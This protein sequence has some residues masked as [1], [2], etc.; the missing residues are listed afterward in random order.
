LRNLRR[1]LQLRWLA[2]RSRDA[3]PVG[4]VDC[5]KFR[6]SRVCDENLAA[7]SPNPADE[8]HRKCGVPCLSAICAC[9]DS[10]T[11]PTAS[12]HAITKT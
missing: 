6:N 5:V 9:V 11:I 3:A 8:Y 1:Q 2:D 12:K 7:Q 10:G 4:F